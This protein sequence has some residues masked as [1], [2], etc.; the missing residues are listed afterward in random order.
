MCFLTGDWNNFASVFDLQS[1]CLFWLSTTSLLIRFNV[2]RTMMPFSCQLL[3]SC[4]LKFKISYSSYLGYL[5]YFIEVW[6]CS[7]ILERQVIFLLHSVLL[8]IKSWKKQKRFNWFNL[9]SSG[10]FL[11]NIKRFFLKQKFSF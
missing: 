2:T 10:N 8:L 3:F 9:S 5:T 6:V 4:S 1:F 11:W 7:V